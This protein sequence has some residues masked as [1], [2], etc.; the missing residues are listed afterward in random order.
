MAATLAKHGG[1]IQH[2]AGYVAFGSPQ[3]IDA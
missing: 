3:A 1:K 2:G